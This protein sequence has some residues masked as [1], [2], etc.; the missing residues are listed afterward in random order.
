[1]NHEDKMKLLEEHLKSP[2][3]KRKQISENKLFIL[4]GIMA[5]DLPV[6]RKYVWQ[7]MINPDTLR[8]L[9]KIDVI[10]GRLEVDRIKFE[11]NGRVE[12]DTGNHAIVL[13][14][15]YE[16]ATE[17]EW[18]NGTHKLIKYIRGNE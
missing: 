8:W 3:I 13:D 5:G 7:S 14:S 12:F 2:I 10:Q 11:E 18:R 4:D 9:F 15:D 6:Y 17:D 1:M 16:E